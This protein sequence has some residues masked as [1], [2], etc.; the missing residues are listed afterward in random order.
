MV[1][2]KPIGLRFLS[3]RRSNGENQWPEALMQ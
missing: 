1:E 2:L 3:Y